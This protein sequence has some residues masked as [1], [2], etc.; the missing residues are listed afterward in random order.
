MELREEIKV[1][2]CSYT[3]GSFLIYFEKCP[4]SIVRGNQTLLN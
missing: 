1:N 3:D 4:V 2:C